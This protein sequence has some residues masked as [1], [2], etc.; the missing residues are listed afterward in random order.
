[1]PA[2]N[3]T[4]YQPIV[5][6]IMR[7]VSSLKQKEI[8]EIEGVTRQA[9]SKKMQS[10]TYQRSLEDWVQILDKAGYEIKEKQYEGN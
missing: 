4:W 6:R 10:K 3:L 1:M 8:A 7:D 2:V 5:R 9:V